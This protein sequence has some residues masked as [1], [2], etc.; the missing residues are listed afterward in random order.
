MLKIENL[1]A[2]VDGKAILNGLNL[3]IK[4][5]TNSSSIVIFFKLSVA[6]VLRFT[7]FLSNNSEFL[8]VAKSA[9]S[10]SIS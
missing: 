3:D 8:T 10:P 7:T 9:T 2:K 5:S 6:S 1:N 4:S